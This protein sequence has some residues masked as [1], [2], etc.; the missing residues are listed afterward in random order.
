MKTTIRLI[1]ETHL[2][3]FLNELAEHNDRPDGYIH[4]EMVDNMADAVAAVYDATFLSS[5]FT[6]QECTP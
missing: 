6:V 1:L 3:N 4:P 5:Q 2:E